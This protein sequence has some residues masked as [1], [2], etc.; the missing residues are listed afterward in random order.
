MFSLENKTA[1]VTG[2]SRGIGRAI[3]VA[4]AKQKARVVINFAGNR[5]AAEETAAAIE[6]CGGPSPILLQFDVGNETGVAEA[7]KTLKD[8]DVSIDILVNNAGISK[9]SLLPRF[10][11]EDWE[12]ILNT[13]L[14][15][16]FLCSK[17]V[18]RGMMKKRWG[19]IINISSVVGE[20]GNAGQVAYCAAKAGVLGMTKSMAKELASRHITVNA[21]TPGY[22][23][24]D[25][26]D[27]LPEEVKDGFAAQIPISRVGQANEVAA[28]VVFLASEEAGYVTGQTLG[29]NG[30]LNM[31]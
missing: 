26:T 27:A 29:V 5:A 7:F 6:A 4:L 8:Q 30:G 1:L 17:A 28:T 13:N 24:T 3:A 10:K 19:R 31:R 25:M 15:G 23:E 2:G 20:Q 9:D 14:T 11:L 12:R 18:A 16:A 21:V 22:I